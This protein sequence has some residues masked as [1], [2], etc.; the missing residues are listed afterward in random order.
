LSLEHIWVWKDKDH[1]NLSLSLEDS[2]FGADSGYTLGLHRKYI[3]KINDTEQT[4]WVLQFYS[5]IVEDPWGLLLQKS[6]PISF[7]AT[8]FLHYHCKS[9]LMKLTGI[10][11]GLHSL[12][13]S[14][15]LRRGEC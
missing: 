13:A 11:Q 8:K 3:I 7:V 2:R 10:I 5:H 4:L 6:Y 15:F 1:W 14:C 9:S 12:R